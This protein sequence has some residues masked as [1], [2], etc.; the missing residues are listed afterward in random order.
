[1]TRA[2]L[3]LCL[4]VLA[5]AHAG[6]DPA[7]DQLFRDGKAL[8]KAGKVDEAC[9]KFQQSRDRAAK[10]GTVLNLAD[11]RQR[12]GRL[13]TAWELF[14][15]AKALSTTQQG[16]E[17]RAFAEAARRA[18]KI[19]GK[20]AFLT[21]SI[22]AEARVPGLVVTR[23]RSEV[24]AS[25]WDQSLPIDPGSYA[26][27]AK[28]RG[29]EPATVTVQ[30]AAT[31]KV[32]ATV[33]ALVKLPVEPPPDPP[34]ETLVVTPS[35]GPGETG[36]VVNHIHVDG[37]PV[38]PPVP[39]IMPGLRQFAIGV[40]FGETSD[41]DLTPGI[42]AIAQRP[43]GPGALRGVLTFRYA[44]LKNG[45]GPSD[46]SQLFGF[47]LGAEYLYAWKSG[48]ASAAG[49]GVGLDHDTGHDEGMGNQFTT[50]W[51]GARVTPLLLRLGTPRLELGV[52]AVV[53]IYREAKVNAID[54]PDVSPARLVVTAAVDWFFW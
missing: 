31:A 32:T 20:R 13:A 34:H 18:N 17:E 30:V 48:F 9:E 23:N 15:E 24:A 28:A 43:L 10:F 14:I 54:D 36:R 16:N 29:Y 44:R 11:C 47:S 26:I 35:G 39:G 27:E 51:L 2:L 46:R 6:A 12:Q 33:P 25:T 50:K 21:V 37:P 3:S 45:G 22:P 5:A 49:I 1:M 40:A 4:L 7:G 8:L 41:G 38:P 52:H 19:A 53:M 42:R